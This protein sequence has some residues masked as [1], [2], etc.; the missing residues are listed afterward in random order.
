E[1]PPSASPWMT[2]MTSLVRH[3]TRWGLAAVAALL[4]LAFGL[5]EATAQRVFQPPTGPRPGGFTGRP[6]G[7]TGGPGSFAGRAGGATGVPGGVTGMPG[8]F[9]GRPGGVT[10]I[11][12]APDF[13]NPPG[14]GGGI[15]FVYRCSKCRREVGQFDSVCPGC[16]AR[17]INAPGFGGNF[18]ANRAA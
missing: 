13:G 14:F 1:F 12:G 7:I 8:G 10:G 6:G 18:G 9:T 11:P 5:H 4:A 17:F 15:R 16:G 3:H 2:P